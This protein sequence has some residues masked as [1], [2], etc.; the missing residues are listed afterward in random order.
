MS[1][2]FEMAAR[3]AAKREHQKLQWL[4]ERLQAQHSG[5]DSQ[6]IYVICLEQ[7]DWDWISNEHE[8]A[9]VVAANQAD[10]CTKE[11]L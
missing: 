3:L 4:I 7:F 5:K 1:Y 11:E 10:I 2:D 8:M 9:Q 6:G